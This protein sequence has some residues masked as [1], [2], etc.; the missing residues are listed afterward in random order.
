MKGLMMDFQLTLP[1]ILRRAETYFPQQEIVSRLPDRV[2][3]RYT[4]ADFGRPSRRAGGQRSRSSGL[5]RGDRVATLGWNH[6]QH[7]EAYFGIPCAVSSCTRSTSACTRTISRTSRNHAGDRAV[8]VDRPAAAA[9]AVPRAH[10]RSSTS[11]SSRTP[12]RSSS[13]QPIPTAYRDP[14]LDENEAS[15]MC[16]TS[17]TTGMPKGVALFAPLD[18]AAHARPGADRRRVHVSRTD[19]MLPVVPMFHAN[20]WGYPY[21]CAL[22]GAKLV[23]PGPH[24]DPRACS[25]TSSRRASRSTAGVPTIWMGILQLA[26][27]RAR[28]FRP[29]GTLRAMLGRRIRRAALADRGLQAAA[30]HPDRPRVGHDRELTARVRLGLRRRA[31]Q[32]R[33]RR[34]RST[35]SRS[36]A[37][38]CRSSSCRRGARTA[39][40]CRGTA[41]RWASSRSAGPGSRPRTTTHP[42]R[43][44]AG[45]R[46]AGSG[47]ATSSAFDPRGYIQ[48]KDRAKDVIK[49]GGEW[50]SPSTSRTR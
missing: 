36:R 49:S 10:A 22:I 35:S 21:T 14:E 45:R 43:L 13:R 15:A 11:S 47:P 50:I 46:T 25:R 20:A 17:G 5:E 42:S 16:Y 1:T 39:R 37:C 41:R 32:R 31:P 8:I 23:F 34:S 29:L 44:T 26:R 9:R 28:P 24:L 7:L 2:F 6:H 4:F 48:I 12:T 40:R 30:R 18:G 19:T 27:S 38:R 33:T 3:H